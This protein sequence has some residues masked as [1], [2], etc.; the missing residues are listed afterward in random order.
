MLQ[1][2]RRH[3]R[4][5]LGIERPSL[6]QAEA[7]TKQSHVS[8]MFNPVEQFKRDPSRSEIPCQKPRADAR[9]CLCTR[10]SRWLAMGRRGQKSSGHDERNKGILDG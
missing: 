5:K 9:A 3:K 8:I 7:T 4:P 2:Q 1:S 6:T 10:G